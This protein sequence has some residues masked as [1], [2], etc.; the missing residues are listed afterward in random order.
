VITFARYAHSSGHDPWVGF[1]ATDQ[2]TGE[3]TRI[4]LP[5]AVG[6][7][8]FAAAVLAVVLWS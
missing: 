4:S 1:E 8:R 7:A 3:T 2:A 5:A 6:R